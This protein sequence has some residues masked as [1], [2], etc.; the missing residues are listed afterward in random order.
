MLQKYLT[1]MIELNIVSFKQAKELKDLGF[2]QEY[3]KYH[4]NVY[5]LED[6]SH[7]DEVQRFYSDTV[8]VKSG[9]LSNYPVGIS[10]TNRCYAPTLELASRWL[11]DSKDIWIEIS[12]G[13]YESSAHCFINSKSFSNYLYD[14][15]SRIKDFNSYENA[16]SAG[17]DK[18]IEIL[19]LE[20]VT[21]EEN[22]SI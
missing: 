13:H 9:T 20:N 17:I 22:S 19:K 16:L 5:V 21:A 8:T 14:D 15:N 2:P 6:Y 12:R 3:D 4:S 1:I 10:E 7:E 11:R 18:S